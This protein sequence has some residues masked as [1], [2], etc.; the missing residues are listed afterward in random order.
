MAS[1]DQLNKDLAWNT[2]S[3]LIWTRFDDSEE[4]V[5]Y[6]KKSADIHLLTNS[7]KQLWALAGDGRSHTIQALAASLAEQDG[8]AVDSE[9]V[10]ATSETLAFMD[11]AGLLIPLS[12]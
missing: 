8:R 5:V 6:N 1:K 9:L 3:D 12:A 10:A 7:A 11:A 4:W 2:F